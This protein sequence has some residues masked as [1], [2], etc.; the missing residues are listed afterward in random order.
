SA[1]GVRMS[2]G[3]VK[4]FVCTNARK[5]LSPIGIPPGSRVSGLASYGGELPLAVL[6]V[7]DRCRV[8][9]VK[10][11]ASCRSLA[12]LVT[13]NAQAELVALYRFN[14]PAPNIATPEAA[15]NHSPIRGKTKGERGTKGEKGDIANIYN[16][17]RMVV[18][19]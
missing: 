10:I 16:R 13:H 7:D 12:S 1:R 3:G 14:D 11:C 18:F 15:V 9:E 2:A 5:G 17:P 8:V 6:L 19:L 4:M